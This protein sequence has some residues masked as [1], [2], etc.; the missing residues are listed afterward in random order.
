[1]P[2]FR[3]AG[4][5]RS[6]GRVADMLFPAI[7]INCDLAVRA[8]GGEL[9]N[10]LGA[11]GYFTVKRDDLFAVKSLDQRHS[12]LRERTGLIR[13]DNGG[14]AQ[15]FHCGQFAYD[16]IF[17]DHALHADGEHDGDDWPA[18]PPEWRRRQET[19]PS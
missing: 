13:A 15:R 7:R 19:R 5:N 11:V 18:G 4:D 16:R 17:L 12:V 3:A 1:M 10:P 6:L 2:N 8:E 14:A 9:D